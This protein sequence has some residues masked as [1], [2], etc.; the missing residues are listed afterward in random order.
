MNRAVPNRVA[1]RAFAQAPP[2][3]GGNPVTTQHTF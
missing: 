1:A 2:E 3:Q